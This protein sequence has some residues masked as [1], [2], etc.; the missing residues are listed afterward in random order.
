MKEELTKGLEA[1]L[2]LKPGTT[3]SDLVGKSIHMRIPSQTGTEREI[4]TVIKAVEIMYV[5]KAE[6]SIF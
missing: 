6:K 5:N 3:F 2:K 1:A 4:F